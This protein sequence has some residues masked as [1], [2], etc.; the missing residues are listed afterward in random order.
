MC[1][2]FVSSQLFQHC[3]GCSHQTLAVKVLD[4][5]NFVVF[6]G[7]RVRVAQGHLAGTFIYVLT[8]SHTVYNTIS[9]F[10]VVR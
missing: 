7:A 6:Y 1:N 5:G 4:S 10:F 8:L 9:V 2:I 3:I